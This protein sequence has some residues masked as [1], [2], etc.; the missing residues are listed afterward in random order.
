[1]TKLFNEI[2][3]DL[4]FIKSHTLQPQWYMILKIFIVLGFL[5]G[6]YFVFGVP[7]TLLFFAVFISLSFLVHMIYRVK[8][9]KWQQRWL[10][11]VVTEDNGN[12]KAESIGK[13]Y[14][15]AILSNAILSMA[16]SQ[17]LA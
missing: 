12:I 3:D 15:L 14:Y 9:N 17:V 4:S 5:I 16:L 13:Y 8:T 7:K 11:F 10:D 1:M 6:Y 2:K